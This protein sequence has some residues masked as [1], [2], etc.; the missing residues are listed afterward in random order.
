MA[1]FQRH[2]PRMYL[3]V[4]VSAFAA[5]MLWD[6]FRVWHSPIRGTAAFNM[7]TL[8]GLGLGLVSDVGWVVTLYR[9]RSNGRF[10]WWQWVTAVLWMIAIIMAHPKS[11][12]GVATVTTA[13]T[14]GALWY[15]IAAFIGT[16]VSLATILT[17][18]ATVRRSLTRN[19]HA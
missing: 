12:G 13:Y 11:P 6:T 15:E 17:R 2:F 14:V 18:R 4:G 8:V 7:G 3:A 19:R 16:A 9:N 1:S 10:A 5:F